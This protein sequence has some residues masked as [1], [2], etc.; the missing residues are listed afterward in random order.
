[1]QK[2]VCK[3]FEARPAPKARRTSRILPW[4]IK[5]FAWLLVGWGVLTLT[6]TVVFATI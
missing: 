6:L 5:P 4:Q 2:A 3:D 1:M